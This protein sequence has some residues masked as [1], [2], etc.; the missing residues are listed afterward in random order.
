PPKDRAPPK[1]DD[2]D[3]PTP[4]VKLEDLKPEEKALMDD[5]I[6]AEW[7]LR[8][9]VTG[10]GVTS[11][12]YWGCTCYGAVKMQNL[13]S[14]NWSMAASILWLVGG[15]YSVASGFLCAC[16][17]IIPVLCLIAGIIALVNL[18]KPEVIAAFEY[19][20]ENH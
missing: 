18:R 12:I 5:V 20:P 16:T 8:L 19:D 15:G 13:E 10:I 4:E 17:F 14:Y 9:L 1:K 7:V 6:A 2:D 11:M 3:K